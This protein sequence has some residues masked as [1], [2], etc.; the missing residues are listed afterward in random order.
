MF[1][2]PV[3]K[4]GVIASA[5]DA[6]VRMTNEPTRSENAVL[7]PKGIAPKA[8]TR[9]AQ[10]T[11]AGIGQL[12]PSLTEEKRLENGVALSRASVHQMRPTVR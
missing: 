8:V 11:V 3:N 10:N 6:V 1:F 2:L 9:I 5:Y 7:L 4:C 12:R